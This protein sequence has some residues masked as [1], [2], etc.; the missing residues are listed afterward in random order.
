MEEHAPPLRDID[1]EAGPA[2]EAGPLVEAPQAREVATSAHIKEVQNIVAQINDIVEH[3]ILSESKLAQIMR[4][5][6]SKLTKFIAK[7]KEQLDQ[8][9]MTNKI[10]LDDYT[11]AVNMLD[12]I[13]GTVIIENKV[14]STKPIPAP[15]Q[16]PKLRQYF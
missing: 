5:D 6:P 12:Q 7:Y 4:T 14:Y 3:G 8:M 13:N 11:N 15:K 16:I 10:T 9:L 1:P 2:R